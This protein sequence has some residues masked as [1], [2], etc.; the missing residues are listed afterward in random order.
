MSDLAGPEESKCQS[1]V[2]SIYVTKAPAKYCCII[3][4]SQEVDVPK[5]YLM[6]LDGTLQCLRHEPEVRPINKEE[7]GS[8]A[9]SRVREQRD[10]L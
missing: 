1:A 6:K 8:S 4:R 5:S 3:G 10:G 9:V 7:S 2:N